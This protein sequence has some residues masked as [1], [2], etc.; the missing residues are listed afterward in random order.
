MSDWHE[1]PNA[2]ECTDGNRF[3]KGCVAD[4][5]HL[6]TVD[7]IIAHSTASPRY[8]TRTR[9]G[10]AAEKFTPIN[11][12]ADDLSGTTILGLIAVKAGSRS[13]ANHT[14]SSE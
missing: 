14:L 5:V 11:V 2:Q 3:G 8:P 12:T 13:Y 4:N 7:A 9:I 6:K 10:K 1:C